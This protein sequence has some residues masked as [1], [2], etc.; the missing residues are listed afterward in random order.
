M[1]TQ[2]MHLIEASYA[3]SSDP[4]SSEPAELSLNAARSTEAGRT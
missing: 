2:L 1:V 4:A 3:A